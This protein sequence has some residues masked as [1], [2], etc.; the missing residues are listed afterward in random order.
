M[1]WDEMTDQQ[2]NV[3]VAEK[4][5][6]RQVVEWEGTSVLLL[7]NTSYPSGVEGLPSYTTD[8]NDAWKILDNLGEVHDMRIHVESEHYEIKI[9]V[10]DA[11]LAGEAFS[12]TNMAEA[13]CKA[14][15]KAVGVE[16]A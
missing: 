7:V 14:A 2:R 9:F 12:S 16:I 11:G 6:N 4:I 1:K 8:M 15:L 13:I 5:F 3:L 10:K